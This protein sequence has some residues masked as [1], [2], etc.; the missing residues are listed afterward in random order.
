MTSWKN[1]F[2]S[3]DDKG[4]HVQVWF[5]DDLSYDIEGKGDVHVWL[6]KNNYHIKKVFYVLGLIKNQLSISQML[7]KILKMEFDIVNGENIFFI[8]DKSQGGQ[9]IE[10]VK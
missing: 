6:G 2:A 8:H 1:W 10:N 5:G 7:E 4:N 9:I 3:L